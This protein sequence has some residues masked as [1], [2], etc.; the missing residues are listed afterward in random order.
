MKRSMHFAARPLLLAIALGTWLSPAVALPERPL[1]S[2]T[3]L[4]Q[5]LHDNTAGALLNRQ[6]ADQSYR[7]IQ[8][9]GRAP[10]F[11]DGAGS[12]PEIRARSFLSLY[13]ALF[14][15]SDAIQELVTARISRDAAGNTHVHMNQ[16]HGGLPVFGARL[17]VH[18]NDDGIIGTSGVF[19][20]GL[21][22][23]PTRAKLGTAALRERAL[24]A[25][26][27]LH[28]QVSNLEIGATRLM[29]YRSGLLKGI[30]GSNHLAYEAMVGNGSDIRERIILDANSGAVL[31]RINEIHG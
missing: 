9:T 17:V 1:D 28:P 29:I 18:M 31:N 22:E 25:A 10:L 16:Q 13:G 3:G 7:A 24:V 8:A 6:L 11:I 30:A 5:R 4:L 27:K 2:T 19:A 15:V 21:A 23:L 12:D 20:D 14:G 26:H